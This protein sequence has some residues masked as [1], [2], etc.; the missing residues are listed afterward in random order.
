M[1]GVQ[2]RNQGIQ[3][4]ELKVCS[5]RPPCSW[6]SVPRIQYKEL[7]A[8]SITRSR[9]SPEGKG[10]QY[11]ELK[12]DTSEEEEEEQAVQGIQYKELKVIINNV[13]YGVARSTN[14]IQR[15]ESI[16]FRDRM[17]GSCLRNPIQRIERVLPRLVLSMRLAES[18]TK[19]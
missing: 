14:P 16:V 3:Y 1:G 7:K 8:F 10:I 5:P 15:I 6:F 4:K 18:N 19:N 13:E 12:G 9:A 2:S 11:K 17:R